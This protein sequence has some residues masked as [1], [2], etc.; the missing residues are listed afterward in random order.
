MVIA[1]VEPACVI[2]SISGHAARA[3][4]DAQRSAARAEAEDRVRAASIDASDGD[5]KAA[6]SRITPDLRAAVIRA[7]TQAMIRMVEGAALADGQLAITSWRG[8]VYEVRVDDVDGRPAARA[9]RQGWAGGVGALPPYPRRGRMGDAS[10]GAHP[11][12][13]QASHAVTSE[14]TH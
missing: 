13:P 5:L 2:D 14:L 8:E 11:P 4:T 1:R 6:V 3:A 9:A 10:T 7:L 12:I